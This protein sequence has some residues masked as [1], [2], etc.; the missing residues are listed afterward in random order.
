MLSPFNIAAKPG[1]KFGER[2]EI[3]ASLTRYGETVSHICCA[4]STED[5][6]QTYFHWFRAKHPNLPPPRLNDIQIFYKK[7]EEKKV[8]ALPN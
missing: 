4:M 1:E 7:R 3:L 5:G 2:T 6:K 8:L